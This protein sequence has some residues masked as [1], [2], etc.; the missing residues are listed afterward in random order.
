MPKIGNVAETN[1]DLI[2]L[3]IN[4]PES[5]E[6]IQPFAEEFQMMLPIVRDTDGALRNLYEVRGIPTSVFIDRSGKIFTLWAVY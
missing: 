1:A 4:V 5:M 2:V 3:A 6:Q